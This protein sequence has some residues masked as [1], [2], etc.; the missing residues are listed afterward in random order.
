MR[1]TVR[2]A[3][4]CLFVLAFSPCPAPAESA[5]EW[6][7]K[8]LA[9]MGA[10]DLAAA[11]E[12]YNRAIKVNPRY[13]Y[14]YINRAWLFNLRGEFDKAAADCT[15]AVDMKPTYYLAAAYNNRAWAYCGLGRFAE[16]LSDC[17]R[18]IRLDPTMVYAYNNRGW[19]LCGLARYTEALEDLDRAID[20]EPNEFL[21]FSYFNRGW[22]YYGLG[23][24]DDALDDYEKSC[25]R[26]NRLGCEAF[27]ALKAKMEQ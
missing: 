12:C 7:A 24:Y 22:A 3:V 27:R 19:A 11:L 10:G 5:E 6:N 14:S 15:K 9:Y 18:A 4:I 13:S 16:A 17:D 25:D 1:H 2:I 23:K 21:S 8:G 20:M 26:G